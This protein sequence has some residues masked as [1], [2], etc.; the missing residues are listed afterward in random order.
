M[1]Q[2]GVGQRLLADLQAIAPLGAVGRQ[3]MPVVAELDVEGA[4]AVEIGAEVDAESQ[5]VRPP[6]LVLECEDESIA[7][8]GALQLVV[9]ANVVA[10]RGQSTRVALG[11]RSIERL[12]RTRRK[13]MRRMPQFR[14]DD[15]RMAASV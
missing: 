10:G 3:P 13:A 5:V 8:F 7:A 1:V 9:G 6:G 14:D 15:E 4:A 11:T 12:A 2:L